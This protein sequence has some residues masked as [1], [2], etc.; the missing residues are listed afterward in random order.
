[1]KILNY[2][3]LF[4]ASLGAI[5]WGL[6]AFLRFNLVEFVFKY[7]PIPYLNMVVYALV[8]LSGLYCICEMVLNCKFFSK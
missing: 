5:N 3:T 8:A 4:L 2:T 6:V 1:M 7:I